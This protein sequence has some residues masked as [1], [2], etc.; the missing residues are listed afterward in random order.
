MPSTYLLGPDGS[1]DVSAGRQLLVLLDLNLP[2]MTGID[3]L[4]KLKD[5]VHTAPLARRRA[6][7]HRR[8]SRD[9]ALL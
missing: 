6:D 9:P 4:Q 7:H 1:G 2:D 5:N 8:Q 3:I